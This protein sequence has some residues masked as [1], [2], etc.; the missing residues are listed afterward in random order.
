MIGFATR[1]PAV[2]WA[3]CAALIIAGAI[4]FTRLPLATRTS[5]ELPRLNVAAS[6]PGAAPEVIEA[7]LTSPLEA[8]I[9]GVRGVRKI[10]SNSRDNFALL[11]VELDPRADVQLTRLA[12]LERIE[13]LRREFPPGISPPS[14]QNFVPE[15]LEERPLLSLTVFGPYT[16]GTLQK[17]LDERVSPRLGAVT[18]VAGVT[19]QGSTDIGVAVTFDPVLLRRIGVPPSRITEAIRGARIVNALGTQT[20]NNVTRNVVMRDQPKNLAD[21]MELP[22]RGVGNRVFRLGDLATIRAEEDSRGTFYRIDGKP[23]VAIDVTRH[24]GADAIKTSA[25]VRETV[26]ELERQLPAGMTIRV[27]NDESVDLARELSD[28]AKRGALAF[29]AVMLVL[30]LM[31]RKT[32]AVLVVMGS[33]LVAILGTALSL[34]VFDIPANM[35][36]LAG[37]GMGVG[38]LVQ[39]ALV[40]VE[41]L[42]TET[43]TPQGRARAT[44]RITPAIIGSTLT[45]AVVLLPFLYLQGDTRAAFM[46]FAM[47]FIFALMWSVFT[48]LFVVPALGKGAAATSAGWPRVRRTYQRLLGYML[49]VR[50]LT[51]AAAVAVLAVLGWGFVKKVPRSSWGGFGERRTRLNVSLS[52]P[53]GSEPTSVD[54]AMREFESI[55]LRRP[56]VEQ[57]RTRAGSSTNAQMSVL[58]TRDGGMTSVPL[59]LQELLTQRAVLIGGAS[60]YV[61]GEGPAF[62]SGGGGSSFAT[63]RMRV[64]GYSYDGVANVAEDLRRRLEL[65]TRVRE[66][67]ISSGG[68]GG[69]DRG[70]QVTLEPDRSAMA[71]FGVTAAQLSAAVAREIRGPGGSELLEIEGDELPVTVKALGASNRSIDEL[72]DALLPNALGIPVR[73]GDVSRVES[74]EAMSSIIREDQQYVRVVSY[75]FRGPNKLAQ[76]THKAFFA[77]IKVPPGFEV[78][79]ESSGFGFRDD[80][81]SKGLWLVFAIGVALVVLAVA[82]VFDSVWGATMVFLSLPLALAGVAAAFWSTKSAFTREAA[83]GVILVVGLAVNQAI[84]L[85]DSALATRRL[86]IARGE[87]GGLHAGH[88]MRAA[89]DR[90]GMIMMV[91]FA[92]LASL[93]PLSVGSDAT[94]LFG[95]IALATAGGT[96]AGTMAALFVMPLLLVSRRGVRRRRRRPRWWKRGNPAPS[97]A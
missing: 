21:L 17:V 49:R 80:E 50:W 78:T 9:Q 27:D 67:R 14:V 91:T 71:R 68:Y 43:D 51:L 90:A 30:A 40:V 93:I 23:A 1:R 87:K 79:D 92:A 58:F 69:A 77:S 24:P 42:G 25:E 60:V 45:T 89:L 19:V 64:L 4:A 74:R 66:V 32:R 12:I 94:S 10:D 34:Y 70:F 39:N 84:L 33:T 8:A 22:V 2:V 76:R 88:V 75:D 81:S 82:L 13:L 5:V 6:W 96:I 73:I 11:T 56:E 54:R 59:E 46:P 86:R 31:L 36:T 37:L 18:G 16:P 47:A 55:V 52:F 35:L 65:I 20:V 44:W 41:R 95:A 53:R 28:L 15:G 29:L 26:K 61:S 38:I 3:L 83:V 57:V 85:V 48:A 97:P 63:F 72:R 62:S 7:Y